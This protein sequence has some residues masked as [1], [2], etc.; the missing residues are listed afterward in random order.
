L[1]DCEKIPAQEWKVFNALLRDKAAD[2][3]SVGL[4][5]WRCPGNFDN[6]C[7][8]TDFQA[9]IHAG[10]LAGRQRHLSKLKGLEAGSF[11]AYGVS[12][13]GKQIEGVIST[14]ARF[15]CSCQLCSR[16]CNG[17]RGAGDG[18]TAGIGNISDDIARYGLT[19]SDRN[20]DAAEHCAHNKDVA[21]ASS[22]PCFTKHPSPQAE[23]RRKIRLKLHK[24]SSS[25]FLGSENFSPFSLKKNAMSKNLTVFDTLIKNQKQHK[26]LTAN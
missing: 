6:F 15:C 3:G 16:V 11:D 19:Q 12:A 4:K 18:S 23:L 5:Q 26:S 22:R 21:K 1:H 17:Y 7:E 14:C 24:A 13:C 8:I 9:R 25:D 10:A 2:S 20:K